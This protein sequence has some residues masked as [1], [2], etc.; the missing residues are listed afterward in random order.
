MED[1][2]DK[3]S[4]SGIEGSVLERWRVEVTDI[5]KTVKNHARRIRAE[6]EL[7]H[8]QPQQQRRE[9]WKFRNKH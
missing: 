5:A 9:V 2:I 7:C 4:Q 3:W 1:F 6:K 8:H